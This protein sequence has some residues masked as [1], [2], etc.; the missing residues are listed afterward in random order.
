MNIAITGVNGFVGKHLAREVISQ[1]HHVLGVGQEP[2]ADEAISGSLTEYISCD[3]TQSW[4]DFQNDVDAV[5]HLAGLAA[6]GPSFE[7]PQDYINLNSAMVTHLCEYYVSADKKPRIVLISSGAIYDPNQPMPISEAGEIRYDSPY[8]VSKVLNESQARYYNGRGL[9]VVVMRPFNHIGPGQLPG[10][11][12]PD[13]AEKLRSRSSENDPIQVGNLQTR[14]DYTDVRD[15]ARAY[16]MVASSSERP[17]HPVYNVS[18]GKSVAGEAVLAAVARAMNIDTPKV[19]VDQSL[20]RPNDIPDIRGD[21]S[22]LS[23]EF[24]W[25]PSYDFQQ[26]IDDFVASLG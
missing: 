21:N 13:L 15:V 2:A 9:E 6:I 17:R 5:I 8:A 18:S 1:G 26:T 22:R 20:I 14:R 7:R 19:E 25:Q 10:F 4:P 24:G 3:L 12:V 16:V 23:S 11:L